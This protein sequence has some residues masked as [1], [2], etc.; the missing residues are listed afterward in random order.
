MSDAMDIARGGQFLSVPPQYPAS[1][2]YHYND[3]TC[4]YECMAIEYM[5]WA[6]VSNMGI[7]DD[8]QTC[9]G[10]DNEWELCTPELFQS[11]DISMYNLITDLQYQL[12]QHA[13]DGN[14]CPSEELVGDVNGDLIVDI[15]DVITEVNIVLGNVEVNSAADIN[16]DGMV[17]ILDIISI[18]NIILS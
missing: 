18:I 9:N 16:S 4:D 8:T 17:N 11:T 1:A 6:I 5:Y 2:W 14:Y 7:L 15:L 10:I 12:P 13:P 3:W